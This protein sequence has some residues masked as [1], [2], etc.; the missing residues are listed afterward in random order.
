MAFLSLL[1]ATS[2]RVRCESSGRPG[3]QYAREIKR[4]S[5]SWKCKRDMQLHFFQHMKYKKMYNRKI[6]FEGLLLV[7]LIG[8]LYQAISLACVNADGA[9][10]LVLSF[11]NHIRRRGGTVAR[12][13]TDLR[14]PQV[15]EAPVNTHR[16]REATAV[17][18][19]ETT[20]APA[21]QNLLLGP[22]QSWPTR[23]SWEAGSWR[24]GL[25]NSKRKWERGNEEGRPR[26]SELHT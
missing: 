22:T 9:A 4:A 24:V 2:M 14:L 11:K 1:S 18:P 17:G 8:I 21:C 25:S 13:A 15:P 20:T 10:R 3:W 19:A 12:T 26:A 16:P 5:S 6:H 23:T 7:N